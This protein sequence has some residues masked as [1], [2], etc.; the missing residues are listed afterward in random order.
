M[1]SWY[2]GKY[3][4][5]TLSFSLYVSVCPYILH[6]I[7]IQ[8]F[9]VIWYAALSPSCTDTNTESVNNPTGETGKHIKM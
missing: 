8:T 2:V 1:F 9:A 5:E 7:L 3:I 6:Q 4:I